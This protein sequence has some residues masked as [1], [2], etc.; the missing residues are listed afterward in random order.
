MTK[1]SA[2]ICRRIF[3][4]SLN[5]WSV[6]FCIIWL[7]ANQETFMGCFSFSLHANAIVHRQFVNPILYW[8]CIDHP[9]W[10]ND[11]SRK[12]IFGTSV[13]MLYLC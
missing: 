11:C 13:K 10:L 1:T 6:D 3:F 4:K 12:I 7:N 9:L 2:M 8:L 5:A